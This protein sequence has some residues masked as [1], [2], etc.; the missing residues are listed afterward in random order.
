MKIGEHKLPILFMHFRNLY[1]QLKRQE[2]IKSPTT[3][4]S[5]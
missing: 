5:I 2:G 4:S 3:T 1:I